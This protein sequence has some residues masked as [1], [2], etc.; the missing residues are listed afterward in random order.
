[1]TADGGEDSSPHKEVRHISPPATEDSV[2]NKEEKA[3]EDGDSYQ[4]ESIRQDFLRAENL[5]N[6]LH[7]L[8]VGGVVI[9]G[10]LLIFGIVA[11]GWHVLLP[12][13]W[14]W[15]T[16]EQISKMQDIMSSA[17]LTLMISDRSK[18]YLM[19]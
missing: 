6:I 12:V 16:P 7:W 4:K 18:K 2:A 17:L 3:F 5:K 10:L 1:M 8:V 11:W 13:H 9:T 15:L 19:K 14:H